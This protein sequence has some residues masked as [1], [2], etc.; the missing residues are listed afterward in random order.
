MSAPC[1]TFGFTV[2]I[3]LRAALSARERDQFSREWTAFLGSRGL[4]CGRGDGRNHVIAS[5]AAQAIDGDRTAVSAW[6]AARPEL[7]AWRVGEL[8]DVERAI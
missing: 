8:I 4:Y 1:P 2:A 7:Q 5:E 6:L 3:E